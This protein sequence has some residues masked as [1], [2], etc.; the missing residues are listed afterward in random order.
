[1]ICPECAA[2]FKGGAFTQS[3]GPGT[4]KRMR[5]CPNGHRFKEPMKARRSDATDARRYRWLRNRLEIR[6]EE[7]MAGTVRPALR[8]RLGWS[9]MDSAGPRLST[10]SDLYYEGKNSELDAA[11]DAAMQNAPR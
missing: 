9:F 3:S 8:C 7:S 2:E 1:V 6:D 4:S 10:N 5:E 11:I